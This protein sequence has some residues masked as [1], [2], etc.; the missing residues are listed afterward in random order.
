MQIS[1]SLLSAVPKRRV[2]AKDAGGSRGSDRLLCPRHRTRVLALERDSVSP[3]HGEVAGVEG[4][5][6]QHSK[7]AHTCSVQYKAL[8]LSMQRFFL[9]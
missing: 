4:T 7:Q 1:P 2:W 9:L 8:V 3:V 5:L 6:L